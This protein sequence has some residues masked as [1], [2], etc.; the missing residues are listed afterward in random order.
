MGLGGVDAGG[1]LSHVDVQAASAGRG[2]MLPDSS[3]M[4]L[5][6]LAGG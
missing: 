1:G 6:I 4:M 3:A 5:Y 2:L